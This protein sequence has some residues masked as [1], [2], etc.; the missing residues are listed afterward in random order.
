MSELLFA[1]A[2][3]VKRNLERSGIPARIEEAKN[4]EVYVR[5]LDTKGEPFR[6][7]IRKL[8]N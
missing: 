3:K 6:I 1:I 8:L 4:G 5:G 7:R 2:R